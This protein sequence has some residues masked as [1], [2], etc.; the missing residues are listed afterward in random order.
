VLRQAARSR[1]IDE[2]TRAARNQSRP[3]HAE[4]MEALGWV[5]QPDLASVRVPPSYAHAVME[6]WR[7]SFVTRARAVEL[8]HGQNGEADLPEIDELEIEP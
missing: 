5:P 4:F 6:A 2:A 7:G 3:T 1:L 8:M